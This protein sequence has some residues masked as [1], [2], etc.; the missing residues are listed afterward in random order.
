MGAEVAGS[1]DY[2]RE[3][4]DRMDARLASGAQW[5]YTPNWDEE[6]K[7]GWNLEDFNILDLRRGASARPNFEARPYPRATA[8]V[9]LAFSYEPPSRRSH[10]PRFAYTWE[11][12]PTKGTTEVFV[13]E[14]VF[15]GSPVIEAFP[16]DVKVWR[17]PARQFVLIHSPN[18]GRIALR[19]EGRAPEERR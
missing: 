17:E 11:N 5:N 7:D 1:T 3:V 18:P 19:I 13:P 16:A 4:Y 8:G 10:V 15:A 6:R 14:A 12:D 2:M 9:P